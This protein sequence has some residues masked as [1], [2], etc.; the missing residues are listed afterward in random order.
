MT[1]LSSAHSFVNARWQVSETVRL[2]MSHWMCDGGHIHAVALLRKRDG[3]W[4]VDSDTAAE[5]FGDVKDIKKDDAGYR[6]TDYGATLVAQVLGEC[7]FRF[8]R[9]AA[10]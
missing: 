7:P 5:F 2:S 4:V 6:A 9:D 8:F 10:L 3:K 1:T